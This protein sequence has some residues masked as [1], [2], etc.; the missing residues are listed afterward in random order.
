MHYHC[1]K[2]C[3][4]SKEPDKCP[5]CGHHVLLPIKIEVHANNNEMK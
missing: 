5:A 1:A 4:L 3:V 2:C